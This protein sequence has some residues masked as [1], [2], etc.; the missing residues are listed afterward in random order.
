L[1]VHFMLMMRLAI[2]NTFS[3]NKTTMGK[4][5]IRT[6]PKLLL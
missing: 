6:M 5:K 4:K 1:R 3:M 2:L